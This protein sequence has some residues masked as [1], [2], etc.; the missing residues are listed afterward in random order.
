[1]NGDRI[2]SLLRQQPPDEPPYVPQGA[3]R[4]PV[5]DRVTPR[6]RTA[7]AV[8]GLWAAAVAALVVAVFG[9][10]ALV[11]PH[12]PSASGDLSSAPASTG[13]PGTTLPPGVIPWL[14]QAYVPATPEPTTPPEALPL[15]RADDLVLLASGWGGATGSMAGGAELVNTWANACRV[16]K[17]RDAYLLD[18]Q[19]NHVADATFLLSLTNSPADLVGI[20]GGGAASATVVWSNWCGGPPPLP[21]RLSVRLRLDTD[22][23]PQDSVLTAPVRPWDP[24]L[25]GETP[26]CD[27]PGASS[28][29]SIQPFRQV[30]NPPSTEQ[31]TACRAADLLGFAGIGGAAAGTEFTPLVLV[32]ISGLDCILPIEPVV[33]L[34]DGNGN[35]LVQT[36]QTGLSPDTVVLPSNATAQT[37]LG[38]ADW[39]QPAPLEPLSLDVLIGGERL[40]LTPPHIDPPVGLPGC[41][42][43]PATPPPS[44]QLEQGFALPDVAPPPAPPDPGDS[45]PFDFV[46]SLPPT[47]RAGATLDYTVTLTNHSP[48]DKP[49]NLAADCPS[50][51]QRLSM[52]SGRPT[53]E[54]RSVLN[55]GPAGVLA[56][57]ASRTF[58]MRL[59]IPADAGQG[60]ATLVW[61]LGFTGIGDKQTFQIGG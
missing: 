48:Y 19:G 39:C 55:C 40:A 25:A 32:N 46:V 11:A 30:V 33:E 36:S 42:A 27:A 6:S 31:P 18:A 59:D 44:F 14:D 43:N 38:L 26:R 15:C 20:G 13:S 5:L 56:G 24:A 51:V 16:E 17:L 7:A 21:L 41:N 29:L 50:F 45:L 61:Q 3:P 53:I 10:Q 47:A 4:P 23:G 35:L 54:A 22:N 8:P 60:S 12:P 57:G 58:E 49:I 34:R 9:W 1:M 52:P 37:M 2:E 28:T